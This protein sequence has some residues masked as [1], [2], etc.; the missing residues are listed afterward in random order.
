[1]P[2]K[3]SVGVD[4]VEQL[5]DD[6]TRTTGNISAG[7]AAGVNV[8]AT[9]IRKESV[10]TVTSQINLKPTYVDPKVTLDKLAT[11]TDTSAVIGTPIRGALL[12]NFDAQ[13]QTVSNVW[14]E[15]MY[16]AKFGSLKHEIRPNPKAPKM[17]WTPRKG[18]PLRKIAAG[19]KQA[20]ISAEIRTGSGQ[21][22]LSHIFMIPGNRPGQDGSKMVTMSRPKG[23][24]KAKAKYG[25]SIDQALRGIWRDATDDYSKIL[26]DS[27]LTSVSTVVLNGL[28]K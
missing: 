13:Q 4:L 10:H 16:A 1:M 26:G 15:A 27:V 21:K 5:A 9:V 20:G 14:T 28:L 2:F 3:I 22:T 6:L 18:D 25:P 24:G 11:E 8:A 19:K 7:V 17:P 23:G 12:T